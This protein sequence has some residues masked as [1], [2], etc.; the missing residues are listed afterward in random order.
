M[1]DT[2]MMFGALPASTSPTS[3]PPISIDG[4]RSPALTL[5]AA[6]ASI[7][8]LVLVSVALVFGIHFVPFA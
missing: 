7:A 3:L 5:R 2:K 1:A 6:V 4:K 8:I